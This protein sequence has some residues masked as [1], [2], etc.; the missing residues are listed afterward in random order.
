M[1]SEHENGRRGTSKLEEL[2]WN[3][4]HQIQWDKVEIIHKK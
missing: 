2:S 1:S 3:E 4:D